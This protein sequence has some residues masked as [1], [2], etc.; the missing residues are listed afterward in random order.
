MA[1]LMQHGTVVI[2]FAAGHRIV[3]SF[4][5]TTVT[6]PILGADFFIEHELLINLCRRHLLSRNGSFFLAEFTFF[7]LRVPPSVPYEELLLRFPSLFIQNFHGAVK[8]KIK[9]WIPTQGPPL[10]ASL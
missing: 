3:H 2:S 1:S 4:W 10:H 7:G 6:R 5:I 9:H 8:H